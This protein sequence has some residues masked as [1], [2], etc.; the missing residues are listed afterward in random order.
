MLLGAM[1]KFSG[2]ASVPEPYENNSY[3]P[4]PILGELDSATSISLK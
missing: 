1:S 4:H 3:Q 2:Q